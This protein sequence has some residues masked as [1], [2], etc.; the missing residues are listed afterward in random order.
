MFIANKRFASI[1]LDHNIVIN[2]RMAVNKIVF[3]LLCNYLVSVIPQRLKA[4]LNMTDIFKH[5][6][7]IRQF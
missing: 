3:N 4:N 1:L 6:K 2:Y 5:A 7:L